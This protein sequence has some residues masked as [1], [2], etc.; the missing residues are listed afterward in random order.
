[1]LHIISK[2][3]TA[4]EVIIN[5]TSRKQFNS[6][7]SSLVCNI[8]LE[9]QSPLPEKQFCISGDVFVQHIHITKL[10]NQV[11]KGQLQ[12]SCKVDHALVVG[13]AIS[14]IIEMEKLKDTLELIT[15]Y[16]IF[17]IECLSV[18]ISFLLQ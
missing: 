14:V 10:V 7:L 16:K 15:N 17:E 2:I 4:P 18:R 13:I 1:M 12:A 11:I 9:F 5:I 3:K 6:E 8:L